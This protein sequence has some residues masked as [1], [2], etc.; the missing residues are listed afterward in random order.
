MKTEDTS[1]PPKKKKTSAKPD[2]QSEDP[3]VIS[4]FQQKDQ[5]DLMADKIFSLLIDRQESINRQL[6]RIEENYNRQNEEKK[7][8]IEESTQHALQRMEKNNQRLEE[9]GSRISNQ[10]INNY[11]YKS[12]EEQEEDSSTGS[13]NR[14]KPKKNKSGSFGAD[15]AVIKLFREKGYVIHG[16]IVGNSFSDAEKQE[17]LQAGFFL[18][19]QYGK[20]FVLN[21][22]DGFEPKGL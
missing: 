20:S 15:D 4:F 21:A 11:K 12:D 14:R 6:E 8:R 13:K 22:P 2:I 7:R 19:E 3:N 17:I 1:K 18:I 16:A 9:L 5:S 10:L